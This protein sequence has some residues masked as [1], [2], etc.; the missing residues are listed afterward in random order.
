VALSAGGLAAAL[1]QSGAQ[2]AVSTPLVAATVQAAGRCLAGASLTGA[3][4]ANVV[5]LTQTVLRGLWLAKL[6]SAAG[7]LL[8]ATILVLAG[9][10]LW[11]AYRPGPATVSAATTS[12]GAAPGQVAKPGPDPD[13][14]GWVVNRSA[15]DGAAR[16]K[17][18]AGWL[19]L[20][21][22]QNRGKEDKVSIRLTGDTVIEF[23]LGNEARPAAVADLQEGQRVE[24]Y[25]AEPPPPGSP[26]KVTARLIV[27]RE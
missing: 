15:A 14:R 7:L 4:S 18:T 8:A 25:F 9:G 12:T 6:Q 13:F 1:G 11:Q 26:L 27:I 19:F 3:A 21:A 5:F 24:V 10:W 22:R 17:G 2:A 16:A 23:R 20:D